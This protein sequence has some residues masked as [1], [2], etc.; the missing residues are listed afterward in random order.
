MIMGIGMNELKKSFSANYALKT[1]Q[2][3][4]KNVNKHL[5]TP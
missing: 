4:V 5:F 1:G 3:Q 2:S